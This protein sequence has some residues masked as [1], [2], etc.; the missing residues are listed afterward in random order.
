M[1]LDNQKELFGTLNGIIGFKE[2]KNDE[3]KTIFFT[4]KTRDK[5]K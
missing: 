4:R 2:G 3:E 5:E 1:G